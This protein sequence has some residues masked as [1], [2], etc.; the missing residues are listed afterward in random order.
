M[1]LLTLALM[2]PSLCSAAWV[3][4]PV[5]DPAG[6]RGFE[7]AQDGV[8]V[9]EVPALYTDTHA[10]FFFA[11]FISDGYVAGHAQP[12]AMR[13]ADWV[14]WADPIAFTSDR[15]GAVDLWDAGMPA[16]MNLSSRWACVDGAGGG[17]AFL[18]NPQ[19]L[20]RKDIAVSCAEVVPSSVPE[21]DT[22]ALLAAGASALAASAAWQVHKRA[23]RAPVPSA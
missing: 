8:F 7:V 23:L 15:F 11:D 3:S 16:W 17:G 9:Y 2:L 22:A 14:T 10:L 6:G 12:M 20:S 21:P 5:V 19:S 18:V 1:R 4:S 13:G